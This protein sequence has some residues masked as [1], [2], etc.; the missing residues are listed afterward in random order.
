VYGRG[1]LNALLTS[2]LNTDMTVSG[3]LFTAVTN[4][5]TTGYAQAAFQVLGLPDPSFRD[6]NTF[7][8]CWNG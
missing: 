8:D 1:L 4:A 3:I 5:N 7:I 2:V 6:S